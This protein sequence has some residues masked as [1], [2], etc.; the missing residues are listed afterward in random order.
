MNREHTRWTIEKAY[1]LIEAKP[2]DRLDYLDKALKLRMV[3]SGGIAFL[4]ELAMSPQVNE[5]TAEDFA[6]IHEQLC[7]SAI[8]LIHMIEHFLEKAQEVVDRYPLAV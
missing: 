5:F 1:E 6:Y 2:K 4:T 3:L 8:P 7:V